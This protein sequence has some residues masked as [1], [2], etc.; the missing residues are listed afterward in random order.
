[1]SDIKI[2]KYCN[3]S[4]AIKFS[5]YSTGE[6]CSRECARGF[7]TREKRSL[8]NTKVSLQS[9]GTKGLGLPLE[10]Q[11]PKKRK[12]DSLTETLFNGTHNDFIYDHHPNYLEWA[13]IEG[14]KRLQKEGQFFN[15]D[16][17]SVSRRKHQCIRNC[18]IRE[19]ELY[20]KYNFSASYSD[21]DKVCVKCFAL[22]LYH[23]PNLEKIEPY[24]YTHYDLDMGIPC[25]LSNNYEDGDLEEY[26]K[27][28]SEW[29]KEVTKIKGE[30]IR[31]DI[32]KTKTDSDN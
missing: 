9:G 2:C 21:Y 30:F 15:W 26:Y 24:I 7:S 29:K 12:V 22:I 32:N 10:P 5:R 4:P 6:F 3:N 16:Y 28:L 8:I 25:R 17:A 27:R 14:L 11:K 23:I 31:K 13:C 1:M 18:E 20:F 19:G